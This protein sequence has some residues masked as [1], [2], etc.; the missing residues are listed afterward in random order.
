M[1]IRHCWPASLITVARGA[2]FAAL[3]RA[4]DLDPRNEDILN[5]QKSAIIEQGPFAGAGYQYR[6]TGEAN[7]QYVTAGGQA[8]LSPTLSAQEAKA[9]S[10]IPLV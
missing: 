5:R 8:A 10:T 7:E 3:N 9:T 2:A 1:V 6:H 4:R